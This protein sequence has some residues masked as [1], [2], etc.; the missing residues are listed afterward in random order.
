MLE[1]TQLPGEQKAPE[2]LSLMECASN[3]QVDCLK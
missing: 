2:K 3:K 1:I